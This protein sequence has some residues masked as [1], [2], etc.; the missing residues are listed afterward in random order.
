[1]SPRGAV[2]VLASADEASYEG[3]GMGRDHP[4]AWCHTHAGARVFY[5]ALG[6]SP[7]AY[8]DPD[9]RAHLLGGLQSVLRR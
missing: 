5:T 4:L 7:E 1:M 9:H 3:G 2:R 8:A 6:H